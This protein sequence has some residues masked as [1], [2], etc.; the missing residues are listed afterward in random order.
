MKQRTNT[1]RNLFS[2]S[3]T[4]IATVLAKSAQPQ[5]RRKRENER[6]KRYESVAHFLPVSLALLHD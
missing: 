6:N 1:Y 5:R 2:R 3:Y 4:K